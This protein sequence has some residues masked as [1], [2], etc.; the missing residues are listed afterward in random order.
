M[1]KVITTKLIDMEPNTDLKPTPKATKS[2]AE[3]IEEAAKKW[4]KHGTQMFSKDPQM[5]AAYMKDK[6]DLMMIA[7]LLRKEQYEQAL[8]N[9]GNLDTIV[10][11]TIPQPAWDFM[12]SFA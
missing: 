8:I 1:K 12:Q 6:A 3:Q 7:A 2:A 11:D 10:R 9:A 4:E 5:V